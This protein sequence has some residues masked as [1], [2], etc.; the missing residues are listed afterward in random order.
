MES[1]EESSNKMVENLKSKIKSLKN[2]LIEKE[3]Q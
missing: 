1:G 3:K 2:D